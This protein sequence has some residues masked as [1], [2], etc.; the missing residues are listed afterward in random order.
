M[1]SLYV[2]VHLM[3]DAR[4]LSL[5]C[6]LLP[7]W[8]VIAAVALIMMDV[9]MIVEVL[10]DDLR[11]TFAERNHKF[12]FVSPQTLSPWSSKV[13]FTWHFARQLD[14]TWIG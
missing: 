2:R 7:R 6:W 8:R 4:L 9:V 3:Q 11:L 1:C 10:L 12:A 13:F 5:V 14:L